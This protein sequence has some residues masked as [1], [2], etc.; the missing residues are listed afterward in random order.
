M[1]SQQNDTPID[2]E[3][4]RF[5]SQYK[6][7]KIEKSKDL[8]ESEKAA[9]ISILKS[10]Q[11][12]DGSKL[13]TILSNCELW[14]IVHLVDILQSIWNEAF[15][16]ASENSCFPVGKKA[17]IVY[18]GPSNVNKK[19]ANSMANVIDLT[20]DGESS[21]KSTP[22]TPCSELAHRALSTRESSDGSSDFEPYD[23]IP[24][25]SSFSRMREYSSFKELKE[26]GCAEEVAMQ[27]ILPGEAFIRARNVL[28]HVE[29]SKRTLCDRIKAVND[30]FDIQNPF[31]TD[32]SV[33]GPSQT[34]IFKINKHFVRKSRLSQS[35][36]HLAA[37]KI[38]KLIQRD[39]R[40]FSLDIVYRNM[41]RYYQGLIKKIQFY[42]RSQ[43]QDFV[44]FGKYC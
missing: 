26:K 10:F 15:E 22:K 18:D 27:G 11:F 7:C 21:S 31:P 36:E 9:I 1:S 8:S 19:S 41:K 17:D 40:L 5:Y 13:Y 14:L 42:S 3:L 23:L 33:Y 34:E 24:D 6:L 28:R 30:S 2:N 29:E 4:F 12:V 37:Y 39:R 32:T 43:Q 44:Y 16:H 35:Q 38:G 25:S 20:L